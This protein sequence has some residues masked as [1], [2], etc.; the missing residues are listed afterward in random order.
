[1]EEVQKLPDAIV[2]AGGDGTVS[3]VITGMLR[4]PNSDKCAIGVVPVGRTNTLGGQMFGPTKLS[5]LKDVESIAKSAMSI[6]QGKTETK[7]VMK[8][9]IIST[10]VENEQNNKNDHDA[11]PKQQ[12]QQQP[13]KPVYAIG[14]INWGTFR[15]AL[16]LR[17]KYWYF[18]P[19]RDYITFIFNAF[20]DN[21]TWTC[22]AKLAYSEPCMGCSNCFE[23][24]QV[25]S[26]GNDGRWWSKFVPK[27]GLGHKSNEPDYS[28]VNNVNCAKITE[29]EVDP[30]DVT[31]IPNRSDNNSMP[32]LTIRYN[33][34]ELDGFNFITKSWQRV[35]TKVF[36][37]E[38]K[39]D[40]RTIKLIPDAAVISD[41]DKERYFSIDNESFEVK[42]IQVTIVPRAIQLYTL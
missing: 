2:V 9:E 32:K 29:I 22:K 11:V 23:K 10:L 17:D 28:K 38:R 18:G 25:K 19:Y 31:I 5:K 40:A 33:H 37:A 20:N 7:D 42:P 35:Q 4:R 24:H 6:V 3:E 26:V 16:N 8:I 27:F 21:L 34:Q 14:S 39:F 13:T 12:Q 30:S 41:D 36:D 1:M 15:D